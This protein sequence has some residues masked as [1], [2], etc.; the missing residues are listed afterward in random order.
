ML[1]T[2]TKTRS[3]EPLMSPPASPTLEMS[4]Q[5]LTR[6]FQKLATPSKA[7]IMRPCDEMFSRA[8]E[9]F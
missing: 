8:R 5:A 9:S 4:V 6:A 1:H 2:T 3:H 7:E